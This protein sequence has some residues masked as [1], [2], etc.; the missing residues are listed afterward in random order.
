MLYFRAVP[1]TPGK[2]YAVAGSVPELCSAHHSRDA[3]CWAYFATL[4]DSNL[5]L[6]TISFPAV[7]HSHMIS[8]NASSLQVMSVIYFPTDR[9]FGKLSVLFKKSP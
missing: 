1:V 3:L 8:L 6:K 5:G 2:S 7:Y 9:S 4:E